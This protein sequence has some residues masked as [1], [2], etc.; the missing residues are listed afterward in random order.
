MESATILLLGAKTMIGR[1]IRLY[2][3]LIKT[4]VTRE[5][6]FRENFWVVNLVTLLWAATL[7]LYYVFIYRHVSTVKGWGLGQVLVV[8]GFYL[9][10]NSIFKS[11]VEQNFSYLPRMIYRGELD[12]LL[13]KP[14]NSQFLVS[15]SRFSLRSFL[16]LIAGV[17]VLF[18]AIV[19]YQLSVTLGGVLV[20]CLVF[21]LSFVIIYSLWFMTLVLAFWLG[22]IENLYYLFMPVFQVSRS[23]IDVFPR[24][25][26]ILFSL[27]IPLVF[28]STVP[29]RVLGGEIPWLLVL[30]G[31]GLAV[32]LLWL[33][34][35]L[36]QRALRSYTSASS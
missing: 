10:F 25:A 15:L 12:Y 20:A 7:V 1:Y 31:L 24:P 22:N 8:V 17:G 28:I 36:W 11:F 35:K 16:R 4:N 32:V 9:L 6:Q 13:T 3:Q 23:P 14:A 29:A 2:W 18:W 30:Y 5:L 21:G 19:R 27:V 26:Q 33:S 34:H